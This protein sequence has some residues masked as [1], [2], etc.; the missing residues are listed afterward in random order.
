MTVLK[1]LA[2]KPRLLLSL[3]LVALLSLTLLAACGDDDDAPVEPTAAPTEA[4]TPAPTEAATE[5]PTEAATEGRHARP[6]GSA[7]RGAH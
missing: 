5:A 7:D 3:S 4:A 6:H 2:K 1:V